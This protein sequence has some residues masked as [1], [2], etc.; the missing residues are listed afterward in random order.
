MQGIIHFACEVL[1]LFDK[2]ISTDVTKAYQRVLSIVED[3]I[4]LINGLVTGSRLDEFVVTSTK[5][6]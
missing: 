6:V 4:E 2:K 1:M 5:L 3:L